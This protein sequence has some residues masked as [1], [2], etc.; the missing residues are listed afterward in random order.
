[1]RLSA[2][3]FITF[4]VSTLLVVLALASLFVAAVPEIPFV[5]GNEHWF[6][7][8]GYVLLWLGTLFPGI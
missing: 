2:P 6:I 8:A 5:T 7:L 1:M 3:R 4:L